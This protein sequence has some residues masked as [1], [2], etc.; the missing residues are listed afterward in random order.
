M[1]VSETVCV[2]TIVRQSRIFVDLFQA[3]LITRHVSFKADCLQAPF[4]GCLTKGRA[5][6]VNRQ[7]NTDATGVGAVLL[8]DFLYHFKYIC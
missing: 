7:R 2:S 8:F 4:Y 3:Q 6:I 1:A 5:V